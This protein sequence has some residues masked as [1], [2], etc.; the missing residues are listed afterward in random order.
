VDGVSEKLDGQVTFYDVN[1]D[2]E[3]G[4][5]QK[6]GVMGIPTMVLLKQG[7][8][9]DRKVGFAPADAVTSFATK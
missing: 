2:H 7:Q 8:E 4:L 6:F 1:T 3:P 9:V 5:A